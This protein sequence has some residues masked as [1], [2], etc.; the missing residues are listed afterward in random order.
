MMIYGASKLLPMQFAEIP[1]GR[2]LDPLGHLAPMGLLWS[3]MGYSRAYS[4]FGA[5]LERCLAPF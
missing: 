1:L 4:F 3:F 5:V 2:L